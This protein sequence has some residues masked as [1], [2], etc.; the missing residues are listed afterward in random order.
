MRVLAIDTALAACSVALLE[1]DSFYAVVSE[2]MERG[3]A[4][5]LAPMVQEVMGGTDLRF[6]DLDRIAVTVGPGSFTGVRVGLSFARGLALALG[7]PCVGVSTLEALAGQGAGVRG[8]AIAAAGEVFLGLWRDG[9]ALVA[10]AR[11]SVEAARAAMPAGAIVRGPGAALLAGNDVVVE[12]IAH[13][14]PVTLA[15]LAASRQPHAHP[16]TPQYL[17][18]PDARLPGG[19]SPP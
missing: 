14:D 15:R 4:E 12:P 13:A 16:P 17:R 3:H 10:P 19:A 11:M 9:A 7:R 5:N 1:I 2:P 18:A 8:G 6:T